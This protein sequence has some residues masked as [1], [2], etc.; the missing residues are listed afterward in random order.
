M[1]INEEARKRFNKVEEDIHKVKKSISRLEGRDSEKCLSSRLVEHR[2]EK[3]RGEQDERV[4]N[5]FVAVQE[6]GVLQKK[7]VLE[8]LGVSAGGGG[9]KETSTFPDEDSILP[10]SMGVPKQMR[11]LKGGSIGC[12]RTC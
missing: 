1:R 7:M 12:N 6:I 4:A 9:Q 11:I 10:F 3:Y 2:L 8:G 5:L